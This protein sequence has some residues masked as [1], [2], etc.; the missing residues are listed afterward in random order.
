MCGISGAMEVGGARVE[1]AELGPINQALRLRGPDD[2][3][4]FCDGK[5]ALGHRRLSIIDLTG[6]HQPLANE[7]GTVL[8][9]CNGEIYNFQELR[10]RLEGLGHTFRTRSDTEVIVHGYEEWG[11]EVVERLDGMFALAVWDAKRKRLLLARD[12]FGKKPLAWFREQGRFAF[13]SEAKNSAPCA[14]RR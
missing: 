6:G 9:V 10:P 1:G 13:A 12:R 3:G 8:T 5:C 11:D 2:E 7:D 14:S 4:I